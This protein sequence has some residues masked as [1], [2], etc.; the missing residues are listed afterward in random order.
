MNFKTTSIVLQ[1][2]QPYIENSAVTITTESKNCRKHSHRSDLVNIEAGKHVGFEVFENRIIV[3]YFTARHLFEDCSSNPQDEENSYIERT[4]S[5]LKKLFQSKIRHDEYYK[6]NALSS[7][8]YFLLCDDEKENEC[9]GNTRFAFA[10]LFRP[11]GKKTS[12]STTWQYDTSKGVFTTRLPK[13]ADPNA[14]ETIDVSDD[15]YIEIFCNRNVYTYTIMEL[16]FDDFFDMYYWS[17]AIN[18]LPAGLYDTKEK[19]V[20]AAKETLKCRAKLQSSCKI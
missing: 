3:S 15:C 19:A 1:A 12:H 8:K 16:D 17:P 10:R 7:E 11:F 20:L 4:I 13:C 9:I 2:I 5:F 14:I 18:T 6:G